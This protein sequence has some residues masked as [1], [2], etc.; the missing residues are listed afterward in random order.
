MQGGRSALFFGKKKVNRAYYITPI[1]A[2]GDLPVTDKEVPYYPK[3]R[4]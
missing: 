4:K 2:A 1:L 3:V